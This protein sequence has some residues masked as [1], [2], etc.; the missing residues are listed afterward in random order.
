MALHGFRLALRS[1][2]RLNDASARR[3]VEAVRLAERESSFGII[4]AG[5]VNFGWWD[6]VCFVSGM[7][8]E[9]YI[10]KCWRFILKVWTPKIGD[11]FTSFFVGI[12]LMG[13]RCFTAWHGKRTYVPYLDGYVSCMWLLCASMFLDTKSMLD[14]IIQYLIEYSLSGRHVIN[15]PWC[16]RNVECTSLT[17][18]NQGILSHKDVW[19]EIGISTYFHKIVRS[20][21][22]CSSCIAPISVTVLNKNMKSDFIPTP[23][24]AP[25]N[26]NCPHPDCRNIWL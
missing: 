19:D 3:L 1:A 10:Y 9:A 14:V 22:E 24:H 4:E 23:S 21:D 2:E 7:F 17:L 13:M 25:I 8:G 18:L 26:Y 6:D 11:Y 5:G 12:K 15:M 20:F 16:C